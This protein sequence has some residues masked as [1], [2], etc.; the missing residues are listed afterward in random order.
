MAAGVPSLADSSAEATDGRTLQ[1]F[2]RKHSA[3]K[4]KEEEE[5]KGQGGGDAVCGYAGEEGAVDVGA[6]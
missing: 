4:M 1:F 6:A 3:L 2:L 5:K